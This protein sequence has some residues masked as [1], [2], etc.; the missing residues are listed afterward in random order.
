MQMAAHGMK[1]L[2]RMQHVK[3]IWKCYNGRVQMVVLGMKVRVRM[4][5]EEAIW[6]CFDELVQTDVPDESK[7]TSLKRR[8]GGSTGCKSMPGHVSEYAT[9]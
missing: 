1:K 9:R 8:R 5:R 7:K 6:N 3:G 4:Q 2:A